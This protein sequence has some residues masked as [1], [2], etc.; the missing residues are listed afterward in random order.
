MFGCYVKFRLA[1]GACVWLTGLH[2]IVLGMTTSFSLKV[3]LTPHLLT[4]RWRWGRRHA[5][6]QAQAAV[7]ERTALP[8]VSCSAPATSWRR[9]ASCSSGWT[10]GLL[11]DRSAPRAGIALRTASSLPWTLVRS[12]RRSRN[13]WRNRMRRAGRWAEPRPFA[14]TK[15]V[16][17]ALDGN[18]MNLRFQE[19][20]LVGYFCI[21]RAWLADWPGNQTYRRCIPQAWPGGC[22]PNQ[23]LP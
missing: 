4:C 16:Q 14:P 23:S 21:P 15:L 2:K 17:P 18:E 13:R 5:T 22:A 3:S 6:V 10:S 9:G 1:Y 19:A 20:K 7:E 11:W 12:P 8:N